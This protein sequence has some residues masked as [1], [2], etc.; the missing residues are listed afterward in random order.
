MKKPREKP[1]GTLAGN[2][3]RISVGFEPKEFNK[4]SAAA[5]QQNKSVSNVIRDCVKAQLAAV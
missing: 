2:K 5:E 1:A 3:V 4:L